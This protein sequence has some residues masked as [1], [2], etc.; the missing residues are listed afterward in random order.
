MD[1][2]KF[3]ADLCQKVSI[4][5]LGY[6]FKMLKAV[7]PG[8][9]AMLGAE[10]FKVKV[11]KIESQDEKKKKFDIGLGNQSMMSQDPLL[12]SMQSSNM[13]EA[14]MKNDT[15]SM[16]IVDPLLKNI[17]EFVQ[18]VKTEIVEIG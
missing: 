5:R 7:H 11:M 13:D 12:A 3:R 15:K 18:N 8:K 10:A 17:N 9:A 16:N 2:K 14:N 4:L 6:M 1:K